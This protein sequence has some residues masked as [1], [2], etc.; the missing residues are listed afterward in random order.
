MATQTNLF[1]RP[2]N[3]FVDDIVWGGGWTGGPVSYSFASAGYLYSPMLGQYV[4]NAQWLQSEKTAIK[5]ALNTIDDVAN[6]KF[7]YTSNASSAD[8]LYLNVTESTLGSGTLGMSDVPG[9]YSSSSTLQTIFNYQ[10]QSWF[11]LQKGGYGFATIVH[12]ILHSVG[13]AHPHDTGGFSGIFPGVDSAWDSGDHQLNQQIYTIMSYVNGSYTPGYSSALSYGYAAGPMAFDIAALQFIYGANMST[14]LGRTTYTLPTGNT[15]GTYWECIWDAGGNDTIRTGNTHRDAVIDLRAAT[16][17]VGD[18][19]AGGFVSHVKGVMGGFTIAHGAVI[20][21]AVGSFG[22][23]TLRGNSADNKLHGQFG[24]DK[25]VG[26]SGDDR[27]IGANGNDTLSGGGGDD[28]MVGGN[29]ADLLIGGPGVDTAVYATNQ[30]VTVNLNRGNRQP[31]GQGPDILRGVEN[32]YSAGGDDKLFGNAKDNVLK[33]GGGRDV[34]RGLSGDDQLIGNG[35][36]DF[37]NGGGGNDTLIGGTGNDRMI[38][39]NGN[40]TFIFGRKFGLDKVVNFDHGHD[41]IDLSRLGAVSDL[42]DLQKSHDG[43]GNAVAEF[44]ANSITFVGV[45][46][47][48]LSA[49]DFIF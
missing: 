3:E 7:A 15:S 48:E 11:H 14:A 27:L 8:L 28:R 1:G 5:A 44:G 2:S 21:N 26:L 43:N 9:I 24:N 39:G 16:L 29:G 32:V 20:E 30:D 17:Q 37:L 33:G 42:S 46:W 25:L 6:I 10:D 36:K 4:Y 19:H 38:G 35:A 40:D 18:A 13:L 47:S 34:L 41:T 23:D 45:G 12:E 31:T 22:D 49:N